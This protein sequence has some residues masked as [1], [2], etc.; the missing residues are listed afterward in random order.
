LFPKNLYV[1]ISS[2]RWPKEEK[3]RF[4]PQNELFLPENG[5]FWL[6]EVAGSGRKDAT[7]FVKFFQRSKYTKV[8][9]YKVICSYLITTMI[10][11]GIFDSHLKMCYF[12]LKNGVFWLFEVAGRGRKD[13]SSPVKFFDRPKYTKV[14]SCKFIC[15]YLITKMVRKKSSTPP[16][17]WGHFGGGENLDCP[18]SEVCF[19]QIEYHF[20]QNYYTT[21]RIL[22]M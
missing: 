20:S 19:K 14:A 9:S 15:S 16:P 21:K 2:L 8:A 18:I 3:N 7:S 5:I 13:P 1:Y 4:S 12:L 10:R 6:F 22:Q 17:K 11:K